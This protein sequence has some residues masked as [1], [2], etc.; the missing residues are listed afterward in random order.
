MGANLLVFNFST[1]LL[2]D[3]Y[4]GIRSM[5]K[6]LNRNDCIKAVVSITKTSSDGE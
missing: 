5:N 1:I 3:G 2:Q 6:A 4:I